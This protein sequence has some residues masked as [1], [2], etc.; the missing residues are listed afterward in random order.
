MADTE[1]GLH[2]LGPEE[3]AI[4]EQPYP[5]FSAEEL[6]RRR[7][8]LEAE[9]EAAGVDAVLVAESNFAGTA[10]QW[11]TNW[12]STTEAML[13][14]VPGE[15]LHLYVQHFNHLPH[16]TK[17]ADG[18][19]V[20]WG[21]QFTIK[22]VTGFIKNARPK[23]RRLGVIGR[24]SPGQ[25]QAAEEVFGEIVD[26]NR[27]YFT[28]RLVKS[29]DEL[30]WMRIGCLFT[31]M[32]LAGLVAAVRPG[33]S[34]RELKAATQ[35][36]YLPLGGMSTIE[37]ILLTSMDDPDCCVPPQFHG[38][39]KVQVGDALVTEITAHFWNYGGQV[40]RTMSIGQDPS[41]LY[42]DLHDVAEAMLAK[43]ENA[44]KPGLTAAEI[45]E[46]SSIIEDAGFSIWDDL[47]HGY[48]GGYLAPVLG[49]ASRPTAGPIPDFTFEP[50]MTCVV[51]PNII[52]TDF[53]AGVQ[54]GHL[55][56]I[57][58]TGAERMQ[59]Y[60]PGMIKL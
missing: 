32:A 53:K 17:M 18:A 27:V 60:P 1:L 28:L 13:A 56:R 34:A 36:P 43:I 38:S 49:C 31:D 44:L 23:A 8:R 21:E 2:L 35:A 22:S 10:G 4:L 41:P 42:K 12:P 20:A 19:N 48:G 57:T 26:F 3:H 14:I 39:R 58:E 37:F 24:L 52:T 30:R 6:A 5:K 7:A 40:L 59:F 51:Q 50:N 54:T 16:A 46:M 9:M 25:Y 29:E 11:F 45:V 33:K 55:M 47:V 15:Q